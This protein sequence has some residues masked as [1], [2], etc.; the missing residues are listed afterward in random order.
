LRKTWQREKKM[1]RFKGVETK[2]K[3]NKKREKKEKQREKD[4]EK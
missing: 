3:T 2:R 1:E 4:G